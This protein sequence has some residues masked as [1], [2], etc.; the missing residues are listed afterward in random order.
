VGDPEAKKLQ[1]GG[2]QLSE[3]FFYD[4][5]TGVKLNANMFEHK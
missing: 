2:T 5:A 3:D 1:S 4:K